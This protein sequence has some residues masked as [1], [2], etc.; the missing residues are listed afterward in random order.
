M[1]V[2]D[3][4]AE[5]YKVVTRW[6]GRGTL[7]GKLLGIA[8]TSNQVEVTGITIHRIEGGKIVEE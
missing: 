8:P 3:V 6:K 5:G 1:T 4:V 2:E 7:Q